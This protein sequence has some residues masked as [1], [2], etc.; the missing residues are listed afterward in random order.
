[1]LK[2]QARNR[3][4]KHIPYRICWEW[5]QSQ[6]SMPATAN[7]TERGAWM[8]CRSKTTACA[9]AMDCGGIATAHAE[10]MDCDGTATVHPT[11]HTVIDGSPALCLAKS[12]HLQDVSIHV[13][14]NNGMW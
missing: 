9:E 4:P 5:P 11:E 8:Y 14:F 6:D 7:P 13:E 2:H 1:M 3:D 12:V 10:A